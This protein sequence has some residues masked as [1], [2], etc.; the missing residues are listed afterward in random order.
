M[1]ANQRQQGIDAAILTTNDDGPGVLRA[2]PL[3]RWHVHQAVPVLAFRRLNPP[4]RALREFAI[5]PAHTLWL[6]RHFHRFDLLHVHALFSYTSTTAMALARA[7]GVPYILRPL[8]LLNRWSLQQSAGRKQLLLRL[9]ERRNLE[10]AAILHCT[11]EAEREE[12]RDLGRHGSAVVVP[13]GVDLPPG[14]PHP[15]P[16]NAGV[17]FLFL[18]RLHPKKQVPLLL[19]ALALLHQR[20]PDAAWTLQVAGDGDPEYVAHLLD[21]AARLG[22]THR[23]KWLG[24]QV[25]EAKQA[26]LNDADWFVLPSASENFGIAAA[27]ALAAGTP[28]ILSPGVALAADVQRAGAGWICEAT[29]AA[30]ADLLARCL[31]PP[32]LSMRQAAR[33]LAETDY[34][35]QAST[36]ALRE[37]YQQVIGGLPPCEMQPTHV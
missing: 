23:V 34:S 4:Q 24:F 7:R 15:R 10:Q 37:L 3:G 32:P 11:S 18:S 9:I 14:A 35:W 13:L 1:V 17:R 8:G 6:G 31:Q 20:Q 36:E 27:E 29:S 22:I 26:L 12:L 5:A 21:Q 25:G 33:Q 30:L 19:Q 2:M 16:T 28:V